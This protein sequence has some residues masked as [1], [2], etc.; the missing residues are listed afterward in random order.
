MKILFIQQI[1]RQK[2]NLYRG[3]VR[4][5]YQIAKRSQSVIKCLIP[6]YVRANLILMSDC[7]GLQGK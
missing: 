5:I 6:V 1:C 7:V 2:S 4:V 3:N